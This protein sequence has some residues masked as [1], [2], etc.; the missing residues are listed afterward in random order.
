MTDLGQ[1]MVQARCLGNAVACKDGL[2]VLRDGCEMP[3]KGLRV[4]VTKSILPGHV[5]FS[6]DVL[7]RGIGENKLAT[8]VRQTQN[9]AF[10]RPAAGK[11]QRPELVHRLGHRLGL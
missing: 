6:A 8:C 2:A 5:L 4:E 7:P 1:Q 11:A 9:L 10:S 3:L